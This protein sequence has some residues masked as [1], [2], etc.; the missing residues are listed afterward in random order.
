[1]SCGN[2]YYPDP[3]SFGK[4]RA[5]PKKK[6][7]HIATMPLS[8]A[9]RLGTKVEMRGQYFAL[10]GWKSPESGLVSGPYLIHVFRGAGIELN[11]E[12]KLKDVIAADAE[13]YFPWGQQ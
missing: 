10:V 7:K 12:G 4:P 11:T 13:Y 2:G 9:Y 6:K 1:M 8:E 3:K 5:T